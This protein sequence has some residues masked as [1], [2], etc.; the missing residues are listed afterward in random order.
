M[1]SYFVVLGIFE[2]LEMV[3]SHLYLELQN[4]NNLCAMQNVPY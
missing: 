3:K 4:E 2:V 1:Q